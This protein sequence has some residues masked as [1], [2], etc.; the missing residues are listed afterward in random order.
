MIVIAKL[1]LKVWLPEI[2]IDRCVHYQKLK[3]N[4]NLILSSSYFYFHSPLP[5]FNKNYKNRF[6]IDA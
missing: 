3:L 5:P 2:D 1:I 6:Y 4:E